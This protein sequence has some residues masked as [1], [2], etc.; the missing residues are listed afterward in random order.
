VSRTN[1]GYTSRSNYRRKDEGPEKKSNICSRKTKDEDSD[2]SK[3]YEQGERY[4]NF[5][6][7]T[8]AS[9]AA[10]IKFEENIVDK[11]E[12]SKQK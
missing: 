8:F 1:K 2:V 12:S 5:I 4:F 7:I 9:A 11:I 3:S 6:T 10:T